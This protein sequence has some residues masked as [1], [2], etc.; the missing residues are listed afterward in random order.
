MAVVRLLLSTLNMSLHSLSMSPQKLAKLI[1]LM[2][3]SLL[4]LSAALNKEHCQGQL[5]HLSLFS[6]R[7]V[8]LPRRQVLRAQHYLWLLP[9]SSPLPTSVPAFWAAV[10]QL[11]P[12]TVPAP[13]VKVNGILLVPAAVPRLAKASLVPAPIPVPLVGIADVQPLPVPVATTWVRATVT[14]L[15]PA[16]ESTPWVGVD[17]VQSTRLPVLVSG[18]G[19][20]RHS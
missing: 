14:Q 13:R 7:S 16:P 10:L 3:K 4:R 18:E 2:T 8:L 9:E 20:P 12:A 1:V 17:G 19:Q 15:A 6:P 11:F 5:L